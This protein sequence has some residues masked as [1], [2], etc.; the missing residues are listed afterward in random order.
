VSDE[1]R[2]V[3]VRGPVEP[4]QLGVTLAHDH[5]LIDAFAMAHGGA[6]YAGVLTGF[7]PLLRERRVGDDEVRKMLV[8]NP[9]HAFGYAARP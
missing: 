6:G 8:D 4:A 1:R 3:T 5:V 7:L 9:A 2:V